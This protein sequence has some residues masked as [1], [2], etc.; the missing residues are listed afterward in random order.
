MLAIAIGFR[1]L[2]KYGKFQ[3]AIAKFN[4]SYFLNKIIVL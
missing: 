4:N 2:T 1:D 3:K